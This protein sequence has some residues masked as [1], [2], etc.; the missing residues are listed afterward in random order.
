MAAIN[1]AAHAAGALTVW[2]LSHS[3]GAIALDLDGDGCDLAVGC[4]YKYLNG[5]PGAPAFLFVAEHLQDELKPPLQGWIGHAEPFAF[6]DD[7]RPAAGIA[8]F[9]TGTP[10]ILALA[11]LDAGLDTFAGIAMRDVEAKVARAVATVH[12]RGRGALRRG[13]DPRLARATRPQRGSHVSFAHPAGLCG[14]AGA[15]RARRDRRFPRAGPDALRLRPA[16]QSL[17]GRMARGRASSAR[18]STPREWDQPRFQQRAK[19]T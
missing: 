12:R 2:D 16:L 7:Y 3:A 18:S 14:D 17:R 13:G 10:S 9:L 8:R 4:G 19:V 11:A 5:G 6:D 15:D 1:D